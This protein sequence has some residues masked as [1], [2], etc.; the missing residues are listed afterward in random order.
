MARFSHADGQTMFLPTHAPGIG[1]RTSRLAPTRT[2]T[3]RARG[4]P[5]PVCRRAT[6]PAPGAA[7]GPPCPGVAPAGSSVCRE[8]LGP[9]CSTPR[10]GAPST[11]KALRKRERRGLSDF[12]EA[13]RAHVGQQG[14][15]KDLVGLIAFLGP[16]GV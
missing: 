6:R 10:T 11:G 14:R 13:A 8:F 1:E 3:S 2:L 4:P 12:R 9:S 7:R 15:L 16:H 5:R